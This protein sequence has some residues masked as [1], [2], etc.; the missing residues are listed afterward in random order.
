[1]ETRGEKRN[2]LQ[3]EATSRQRDIIRSSILERDEKV[4]TDQ[5]K[6]IYGLAKI[7]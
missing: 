3:R 6:R 1:M 4:L 2:R 5:Q 7:V